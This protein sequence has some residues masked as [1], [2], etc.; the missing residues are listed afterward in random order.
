MP[1]KARRLLKSCLEKD[2]KGRLR[3]I[4]DAWRLLDDAPAAAQSGGLWRV[5]AGALGVVLVVGAMWHLMRRSDTTLLE[6]VRLDLDLGPD[7]S[8]GSAVGSAVILSPDGARLVIVSQSP[9]GTRFLLT[10]LLDQPKAVRLPGTE[11]AYAPFFSPDGRW[12]GFFARGKLKKTRLDGGEP[13][14]LCDAPQGRGASWGEDGNVIAALNTLVGLSVV[15]SGGGRPVPLT[16]LGPGELSHRW[17]QVLPQGKAV[18][19]A[20]G[21][22]YAVND[23]SRIAVVTLKDHKTKTVLENAGMYPRYLSSGHLVYVKKGSLFA[24]PF[25]LAGLKVRAAATLLEEVSSNTG[26]GFAH[27]DFSQSGNFVYRNGVTESLT[28]IRWLDSTGKTES[29]V[30][31]PAL[32]LY[33]RVSPDSGR[34]IYLVSQRSSVDLWVYD[35]LRDSKTRLTNG[36]VAT[37]PV[38]SPDSRFVVFQSAEGMHW[39]RTDGRHT[40]TSRPKQSSPRYPPLSVPTAGGSSSLK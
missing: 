8:L 39:T 32:Y 14:S 36:I 13:M 2:P 26:L 34:L 9:D 16:E 25:D 10:R 38:W 18:L 12:V 27:M 15:P 21:T 35:W 20:V 33:P 6:A 28:T 4:A 3:D 17:P 11:G 37:N 40:A 24:T 29:L 7:V 5:A 19:F 23:E 1:H 30:T 31:D 22:S